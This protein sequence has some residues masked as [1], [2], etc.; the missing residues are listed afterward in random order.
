MDTRKKI[1]IAALMAI[2]AAVGYGG[3]TIIKEKD[4]AAMRSGETPLY[5]VERV[6]DGDTFELADKD[7]VRLLGIDAPEEGEC[8]YEES[9]QALDKLLIG[10]EVELRKDVT[11]TDDFGRLLRY[12][13]LSDANPLTDNMLVDEYMVSAGYAEPQSNPRDK[14]YWGILLEQREEAIRESRGM[15]NACEYNPAEH[16]Q[17][18]TKP[19]NAKCT[20]KGNISIDTIYKIYFVPECNNYSQVKIDPSRGEKYF[21]SEEEA[22]EA[23]FM[24]ARYCP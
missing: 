3:Y 22:K 6:I 2:L 18:D 10:K 4:L 16:S 19:G 17:N 5:K 11:A 1:S 12:A 24:K 7:V 20:V 14:L 15:W 23:G 8:Y 13:I 21:C 9:K